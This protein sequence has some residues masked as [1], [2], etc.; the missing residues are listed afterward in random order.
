MKDYTCIVTTENA[1]FILSHV[2]PETIDW[3]GYQLDDNKQLIRVQSNGP[4]GGVFVDRN[5]IKYIEFTVNEDSS[6]E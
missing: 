3:I 4:G 5:L 6:D 1:E 2:S